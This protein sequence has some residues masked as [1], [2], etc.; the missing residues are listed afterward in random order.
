MRAVL[1][2][3]AVVT[4]LVL[5]ATPASAQYAW[6]GPSLVG[7]HTP[8]GLSVLLAANGPGDALGVLAHWRQDRG[9][10]GLGYRAG[11]VQSDADDVAV[12]GG[13]DVSGVLAGSIEDADIQVLWWSGLGAGLGDELAVT[14]PVGLVAGWRGV[15]DG[16]VFAP[17][18]GA[19][20]ALDVASGEGDSLSLDA[21][22]DLG[23]DLTL[24]SGWVVRFG[25][26]LFGREALGVGVRI[27]S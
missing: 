14:V 7:P 15:G 26:S 4:V 6:D 24:V 23:L 3:P 2:S 27:P 22:L 25:A 21:S 20:V 17:Y 16:N 5:A 18:A 19:H 11:L 1:V 8:Q 9:A 12:F 13:V 10:F